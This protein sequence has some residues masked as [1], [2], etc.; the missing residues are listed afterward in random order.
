MLERTVR[1]AVVSF[2]AGG[3]TSWR[4]SPSLT[5]HSCPAVSVTS[6]S[7]PATK[8]WGWPSERMR[9]MELEAAS[10]SWCCAL[11]WASAFSRAIWP[12]T[13]L[14]M[15]ALVSGV[16]GAGGA[17]DD[18]LVIVLG[19]AVLATVVDGEEEI[20][21]AVMLDERRTFDGIVGSARADGEFIS[22]GV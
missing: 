21:E 16:R 19:E 4:T 12:L 8:T 13:S 17:A 18:L 22:R 7:L 2:A 11:A 1:V 3:W 9:A 14:A 10:L 15:R 6:I 5:A 20:V